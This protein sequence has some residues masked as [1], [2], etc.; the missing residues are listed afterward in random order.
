[1]FLLLL[2]QHTE[3]VAQVAKPTAMAI[4]DSGSSAIMQ[5]IITAVATGVGGFLL[6]SM[7]L[8]PNEKAEQFEEAKLKS[9]A[10]NLTEH[11]LNYNQNLHE[12]QRWRDDCNRRITTL[13]QETKHMRE[14]MSEKI[15]DLAEDVAETKDISVE[16]RESLAGLKSQMDAT[17]KK[18]S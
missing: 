15:K 10:D 7:I 9:I 3:P 16:I 5:T 11:K 8:R 2:L 12:W 18:W 13:E 17:L 4:A 14:T 1:M 6:R